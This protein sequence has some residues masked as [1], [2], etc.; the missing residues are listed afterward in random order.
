MIFAIAGIAGCGDPQFAYRGYTDRS[1]CNDV[2][3]AEQSQ[4]AIIESRRSEDL[5]DLGVGVVDVIRMNAGVYGTPM[6]VDV[7][8]EKSGKVWGIWYI[9][10]PADAYEEATLFDYLS[11]QL[12]S[13]FGAPFE[14]HSGVGRTGQFRCDD[15]GSL[16][17]SEGAMG[18]EGR[19]YEVAIYVEI[20]RRCGLY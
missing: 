2:I 17:L 11:E 6:I 1:N 5:G 12:S 18:P 7:A 16:G 9:A 10:E 3:D 4:G 15:Q 19:E 13:E 14:G 20:G 8:C